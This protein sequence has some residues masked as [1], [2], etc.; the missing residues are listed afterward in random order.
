M[1]SPKPSKRG[2]PALNAKEHEELIAMNSCN[3]PIVRIASHFCISV[4]TVYAWL[5]RPLGYAPKV[6]RPKATQGAKS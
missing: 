6:G 5:S 3:V 4:P 1:A 2:K